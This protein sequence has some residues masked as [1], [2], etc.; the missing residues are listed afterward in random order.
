M[1]TIH[2]YLHETYKRIPI[3]RLVIPH[4]IGKVAGWSPQVQGRQKM[5]LT[6]L[7]LKRACDPP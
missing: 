4:K 3:L 5:F 6:K 2:P 1:G 7:I